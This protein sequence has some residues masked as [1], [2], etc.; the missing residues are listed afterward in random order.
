MEGLERVA[1]AIYSPAALTRQFHGEHLQKMTSESKKS[2]KRH[3]LSDYFFLKKIAF[4]PCILIMLLY[5]EIS[6]SYVS[7][8]NHRPPVAEC[9]TNAGQTAIP[10]LPRRRVLLLFIIIYARRLLA[11]PSP[12]ESVR[13]K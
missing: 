8:V 2:D 1:S 13:G 6:I 12:G 5:F 9:K 3:W 4:Y 10:A 7:A 11:L